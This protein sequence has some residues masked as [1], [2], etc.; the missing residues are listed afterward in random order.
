MENNNLKTFSFNDRIYKTEA[1]LKRAQTIFKKAQKKL[2][3][4]ERYLEKH[5]EEKIKEIIEKRRITTELNKNFGLPVF[6]TDY[7]PTKNKQT[8]DQRLDNFNNKLYNVKNKE[9]K[10]YNQNEKTSYTLIKKEILNSAFTEISI[11]NEPFNKNYSIEKLYLLYTNDETRTS[12][13][14]L[15]NLIFLNNM[16]NII[17]GQLA[18]KFVN[19]NNSTTKTKIL[20]ALMFEFTFFK[21]TKDGF[22]EHTQHFNIASQV[23]K[24][25]NQIKEYSKNSVEKLFEAILENHGGSAGYFYKIN[26]IKILFARRKMTKAGTYIKL[27]KEI[28]DKRA[29][30]NIKNKDDNYC[31]IWCLL[32]KKYYDT[33]KSKDRN[34]LYHYKK[35]FKEIIQPKD[36]IYPIDIQH[37]IPKF[38][39]LNNTKIN[40]FQYDKKFTKLETL[41]N[42]NERNENV[43]NLLLI[44][45]LIEDG[46][47]NDHLIW[48]KSI[49]RY[50]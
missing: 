45:H 4:S 34:E 31:L 7:Q 50:Y 39:K 48:I 19:E 36:I 23:L 2:T 1:S 27:P 47:K 35:H 44:D 42:T 41:Y 32:T 24:S 18:K 14:I 9:E 22:E 33:I 20:A 10:I 5:G 40:V 6:T 12:E 37:D 3:K 8:R 13:E 16:E 25:P 26:E 15:R 38:E 28:E 29:C 46:T 21:K 43:I 30:V 49:K 11:T 17:Y